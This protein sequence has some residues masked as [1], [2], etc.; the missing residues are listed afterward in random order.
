MHD[1]IIIIIII[2]R[3]VAYPTVIEYCPRV[4]ILDGRVGRRRPAIAAD[5]NTAPA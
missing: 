3:R 5:M 2:K 1:I 4:R